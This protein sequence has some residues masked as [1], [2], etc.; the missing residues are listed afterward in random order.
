MVGARQ[1]AG[2][3]HASTA[4]YSRRLGDAGGQWGPGNDFAAIG[5]T[6]KHPVPGAQAAMVYSWCSPP[7]TGRLR[8]AFAGTGR[9]GGSQRAP[10]GACMPSPR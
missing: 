1:V 5:D 9:T 6:D 4:E 8:T 7:S 3:R 2:D 10:T